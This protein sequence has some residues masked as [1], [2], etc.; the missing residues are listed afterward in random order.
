VDGFLKHRY[1]D[2][3]FSSLFAAAMV[4]SILIAFSPSIESWIGGSGISI[5]VL[6][7]A[8]LANVFVAIFMGNTLFLIFLNKIRSLVGVALVGVSIL[9]VGGII[10]AQVGF[11]NIVLAYLLSGV[12]MMAIS[13]LLVALALK[14][15]AS[16][17][18]SRYM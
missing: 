18:F 14:K 13:T 5:F 8:A 10:L 6:R 1:Y 16:L 11:E 7:V 4:A 9:G 12:S 2:L 3:L 15:P 17:F